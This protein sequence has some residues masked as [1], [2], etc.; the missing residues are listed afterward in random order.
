MVKIQNYTSSE[1]SL[2]VGIPQGSALGPLLFLLLVNDLSACIN[3]SEGN[4]FADDT[5]L[6]SEG[7]GY[8]ELQHNLQT[9]TAHI[10]TVPIVDNGTSKIN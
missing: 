1:L 4:Y 3:R 10:G 9:D 7:S 8:T 6:H 2:S 5:M